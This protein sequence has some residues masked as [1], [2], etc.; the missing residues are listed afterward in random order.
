[1]S[2]VRRQLAMLLYT[3]VVID[4]ID[5]AR[6]TSDAVECKKSIKKCLDALHESLKNYN[7]SK[8]RVDECM[9]KMQS[10]LKRDE[11]SGIDALGF[12]T[13]C[14]YIASDMRDN[15]PE[16]KKGLWADLESALFDM[17]KLVDPGIEN[18]DA[19]NVGASAGEQLKE[20]V[21]YG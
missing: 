10:V 8:I 2:A 1:M 18:C 4:A 6:C 16:H 5:D 20:V 14:M 19:I 21:F 15:A 17:Y 9:E 12:V 13:S 7:I 11:F 3:E